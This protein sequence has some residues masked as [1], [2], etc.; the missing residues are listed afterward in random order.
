MFIVV[1]FIVVLVSGNLL[2]NLLTAAQDEMDL[3]VVQTGDCKMLRGMFKEIAGNLRACGMTL[4]VSDLLFKASSLH[5]V[6]FHF[7][8]FLE[9]RFACCPGILRDNECWSSV[10][11]LF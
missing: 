4:I 11:F 7:L 5:T 2:D 6:K 9:S 8:R 3:I 1:L 10:R